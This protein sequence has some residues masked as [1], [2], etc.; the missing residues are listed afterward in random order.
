MLIIIWKSFC[1][2]TR[3]LQVIGQMKWTS[4]LYDIGATPFDDNRWAGRQLTSRGFK[5]GQDRELLTIQ[6]RKFLKTYFQR[7]FL[8]QNNFFVI[9]GCFKYSFPRVMSYKLSR[10]FRCCTL[11]VPRHKFNLTLNHIEWSFLP[12]YL[13][14][15]INVWVL[16]YGIRIFLM[17]YITCKKIHT[18]KL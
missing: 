12:L 18:Y 7:P 5:I 1:D 17:F 8:T 15:M 16:L 6:V 9:L 3:P 10:K 4:W 11:T 2:T 13:L 14:L